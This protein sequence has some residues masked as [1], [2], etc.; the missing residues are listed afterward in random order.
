MKKSINMQLNDNKKNYCAI[1]LAF[2]VFFIVG[3][4]PVV[5]ESREFSN[6]GP[7]SRLG[8][9]IGEVEEDEGMHPLT[10]MSAYT[11]GQ[12]ATS[13]QVTVQWVDI[14]PTFGIPAPPPSCLRSV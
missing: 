12:D 9:W 4:T 7:C 1:I 6:R 11:P 13:G 3:M 8:T 5:S 2:V 14:D 10:F